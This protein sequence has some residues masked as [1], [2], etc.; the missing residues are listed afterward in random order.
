MTIP[1]D[2]FVIHGVID[3][4]RDLWS[5]GMTHPT[6]LPAAAPTRTSDA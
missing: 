3:G 6:A 4:K 1:R 5:T 2:C